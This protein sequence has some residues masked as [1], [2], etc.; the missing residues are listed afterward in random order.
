MLQIDDEAVAALEQLG[1]IRITA[2]EVDGEVEI[3]IDEAAEPTEGDEVIER[4]EVR[5][6][7]DAAAADAL[8]DQ[9]PGAQ[10]Q[11]DLFRLPR[12]RTPPER[13]QRPKKQGADP[14][15]PAPAGS[16]R[17]PPGRKSQ[18]SPRH[19]RRLPPKRN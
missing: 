2:E 8:G 5:V 9:V 14:G 10:A 11:E 3:S 16:E 13:G 19:V 18:A 12:E 6:F 4:G 17:P 1:T 7:L 15:P